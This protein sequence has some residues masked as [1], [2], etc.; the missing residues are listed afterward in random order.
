[1]GIVALVVLSL[2]VMRAVFNLLLMVLAAALIAIYFHAL[3]D[4]IQRKTK[5]HRNVCMAISL[6]G[7]LGILF[8]FFYLA[9]DQLSQQAEAISQELP[10]MVNDIQDD[11]R[12]HGAGREAL[13]WISSQEDQDRVR[14]VGEQFFTSTFGVLGDLYVLLILALFFT[15]QPGIY[16]K[17]MVRLLPANAREEG[18]DVINKTGHVGPMVEGKLAVH[19]IRIHL[20]WG[21]PR[22][23]WCAHG[24]DTCRD[25]WSAQLHSQFRS[26]DR[27]DPCRIGG[28][29]GRTADHAVCGDPVC[30][31]TG[32]GEHTD[33]APLQHKHI[34]MPPAL[35]IVSQI[36]MGTLA[37]AWG[38]IMAT[39][40]VGI[41]IVLVE[42]LYMKRQ[43]KEQ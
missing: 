9:G 17:G 10:K 32:T 38:V 22:D 28:D 33:P 4:L 39:P 36:G 34:H 20:Q 6:I 19:A 11:M 25:R 31:C 18:K 24:L 5:W 41:G 14:E 7:T 13:R 16:R 21:W 37:G 3:G 27:V 42:Q 26:A 15:S 30:S 23:T 2:F 12:Q 29:A 1:M 35:L 40:L 8:G 43:D